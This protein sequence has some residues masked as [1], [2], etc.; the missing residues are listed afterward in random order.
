MV[1]VLGKLITVIFA[2]SA[3]ISQAGEFSL[4]ERNYLGLQALQ[5]YPIK[6]TA[7]NYET[8]QT[9]TAFIYRHVHDEDW[10][11]EIG[12]SAKDFTY[13]QENSRLVF[14]TISQT[15]YRL[16]RLDVK[17]YL[18][19]GGRVG[20]MYPVQTIGIPPK[21]ETNHDSE[22]DVSLSLAYDYFVHP[23]GVLTLRA[24]LWRGTST[25]KFRGVEIAAG[26]SRQLY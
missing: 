19:V 11:T 22:V 12:S 8:R 16:I 14:F 25:D 21:R 26:F 6:D 13:K 9:T 24:D 15:S 23:K 5:N 17:H 1:K 4:Y 2:L 20:Y 7:Q 3:P 18:L 10:L